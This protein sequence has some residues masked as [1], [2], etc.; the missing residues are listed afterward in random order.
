M[1]CLTTIVFKAPVKI[2][3][4]AKLPLSL[5]F[6]LGKPWK[7]NVNV[8][9]TCILEVLCPVLDNVILTS[10]C[11]RSV[12]DDCSNFTCPRGYERNQA[13]TSLRCN[14][15]GTWSQTV[16]LCIGKSGY[17]SINVKKVIVIVR[18]FSYSTELFIDLHKIYISLG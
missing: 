15:G 1:H 16:P 8:L 2:H 5:T 9:Q 17:T 4:R 6:V 18:I 3:I 10:N 7:M 12:D 14:T 13:V 11:R